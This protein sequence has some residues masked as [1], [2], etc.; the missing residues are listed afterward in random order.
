MSDSCIT[1][2]SVVPY[3][4]LLFTEALRGKCKQ[5]DDPFS[6]SDV[7]CFDSCVFDI[8]FHL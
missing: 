2:E 6:K 3:L 7:T 1:S 5:I 4:H 8:I